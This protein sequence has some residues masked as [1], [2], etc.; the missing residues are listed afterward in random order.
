MAKIQPTGRFIF[1]AAKKEG[2]S[3]EPK[4]PTGFRTA[5]L[6]SSSPEQPFMP[7]RSTPLGK[8]PH[9]PVKRAGLDNAGRGAVTEE[10]RWEAPG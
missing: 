8:E 1:G 7:R 5:R 2:R 4:S 6:Q 10:W 9:Q 3:E